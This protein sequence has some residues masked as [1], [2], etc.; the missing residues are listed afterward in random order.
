[1]ISAKKHRILLLSLFTSSLFQGYFNHTELYYGVYTNEKVNDRYNM[2]Y[3]YLLVG[4]GYA[5]ICIM[6]LAKR[7]VI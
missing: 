6:V 1:M 2:K 3:A 7:F 4:G 5:M